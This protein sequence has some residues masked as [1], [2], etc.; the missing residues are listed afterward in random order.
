MTAPT[1]PPGG[2]WRDDQQESGGVPL[3]ALPPHLISLP[4]AGCVVHHIISLL[5][6][7]TIQFVDNTV[8]HATLS[9][10][11]SAITC[12]LCAWSPMRRND[13]VVYIAC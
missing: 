2:I 12:V 9:S 7:G 8:P 3:R 10:G 6:G 1:H 11:P 13:T 5:A 4:D